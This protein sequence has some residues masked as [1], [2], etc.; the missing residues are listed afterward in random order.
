[1]MA[2]KWRAT[3][4]QFISGFKGLGG[5]NVKAVSADFFRLRVPKLT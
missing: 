1:M 2:D 3:R 4:C 5:K